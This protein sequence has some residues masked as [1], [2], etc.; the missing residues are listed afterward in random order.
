MRESVASLSHVTFP[1]Q[2]SFDSWHSLWSLYHTQKLH[3][4]SF[5]LSIVL[6]TYIVANIFEKTARKRR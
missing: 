3:C 1:L 2:L 4:V 5:T 6:C